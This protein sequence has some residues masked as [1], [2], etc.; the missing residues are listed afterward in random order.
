LSMRNYIDALGELNRL[1][2]EE[3][4]FNTSI[5]GTRGEEAA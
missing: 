5:P 2:K 1:K 3:R 4:E